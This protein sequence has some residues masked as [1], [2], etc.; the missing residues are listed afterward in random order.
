MRE[1]VLD[2]ETT[3]LDPAAGHRLVE[4][5][6]VELENHVPTGRRY[7]AYVNPEREV[8]QEAFAVHGLSWTFLAAYPRFAALAED[9]LA[10]LGDAPLVIHNASF[11][12]RFLNHELAWAGHDP[13]P[14][15]QAVDTLAMA[16]QRFPGAQ[17]NLDALCKRFGVNN[18][19]RELHGALLDCDLLAEV[20]LHLRGGRQPGLALVEAPTSAGG[21][22][23]VGIASRP[24]REP[25]P[26]APA[27]AE[28]E[29]HAAMCDK[30]KNPLWQRP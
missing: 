2:T 9:I 25:R 11:D 17:V 3:G 4:V 8:P 22:D 27:P 18:A 19:A 20:Y 21:D 24:R 5:A 29:A 1:V 26:H 23:R 14:E 30:L 28:R 6:G 7:H 10:F 12:M 15:T 13:L 16:R